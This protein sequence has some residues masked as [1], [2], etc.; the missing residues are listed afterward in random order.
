MYFNYEKKLINK[1]FKFFVE[2]KLNL[3]FRE[4]IIAN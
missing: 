1:I 2:K 3:I 4:K